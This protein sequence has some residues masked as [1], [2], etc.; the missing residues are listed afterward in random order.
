MLVYYTIFLVPLNFIDNV[1][2]ET[3]LTNF[4]KFY[5][6]YSKESVIK[7]EVNDDEFT[8]RMLALLKNKY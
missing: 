4:L 2:N 3:I 5:N 8:K 1:F 6:G 7:K